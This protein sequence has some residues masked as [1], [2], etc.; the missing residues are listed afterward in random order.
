MC[1]P[2]DDLAGQIATGSLKVQVGEV[3]LDEIV[4]AHR[5]MHE[6]KAACKIVVLT[7]QGICRRDWMTNGVSLLPNNG[8]PNR[9]H[10]ALRYSGSNNRC[11]SQSIRSHKPL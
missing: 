7:L 5:C 1:T 11:S 2:L 10:G 8:F 6:N 9:R 3:R 4:E